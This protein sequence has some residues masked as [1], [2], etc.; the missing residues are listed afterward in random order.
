MV[1]IFISIMPSSSPNLMLDHSLESSHRDDSNKLSDIRFCEELMQEVWIEVDFTI[2]I[3][4]FDVINSP[5]AKSAG[6]YTFHIQYYT[7]F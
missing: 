5:T 6:C 2:L 4:S 7:S 3:W 1:N